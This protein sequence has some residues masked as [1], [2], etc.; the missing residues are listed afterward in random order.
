LERWVESLKPFRK[1]SKL[2]LGILPLRSSRHADF[3][4]YEVPGMNI[5]QWIHDRLAT[6]S[7]TEQ[8]SEEGIDICVEFLRDA[9]SLVDGVY[10]MPPFKKYQM[11][12]D[13]LERIEK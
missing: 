8:Q 10:M 2:M 13:I 11:A 4:H 1:N 7:T 3:L 6:R 9:R 5:P 12:V